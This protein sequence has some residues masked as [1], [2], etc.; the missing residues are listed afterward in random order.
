[1]M[2]KKTHL[3]S[4]CTV[5]TLL[6]VSCSSNNEKETGADEKIK[7]EFLK[8]IEISKATYTDEED[9]LIL[10]GKVDYDDNKVIYYTPLISGIAENIKFQLGDKVSKGETM[11]EVRS[12]DLTSLQSEFVAAETDLKVAERELQT[13]NSL[14]EDKM[15]SQAELLE[16]QAKVKQAQSVLDKTKNDLHTYGTSDSKGT[17]AIKSPM[18]G[19]V[20][21]KNVSPG[22][23]ISPDGDPIFVIADLNSV[24]ITANVYASNLQFVKQGMPVEITTLSYPDKVFEGKISKLSQVFDPEEK[25]L[26]ARIVMPNSELLFK[27]EMSV[28][29]TIKK[30]TNQKIISI[31]S[32][33]IVFDNNKNYVVVET[34][35]DKFEIREIKIKGHYKDLTYI[36]SG[37]SDNENIVTKNQLLIFSELKEY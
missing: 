16:A 37:L 22:S 10:N 2:I 32:K 17:F 28:M 36:E 15:L 3:I 13:A 4:L 30:Q 12:S 21:E 26:K 29:V 25:V 19:Y 1:M 33:A 11:L 5:A 9:E 34:S 14:Y 6:C 23:T 18:T 31:P 27:P 7:K 8:D 24:S 35:P 20:V